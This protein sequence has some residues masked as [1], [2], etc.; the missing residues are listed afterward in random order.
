MND[1]D[2]LNDNNYDP[3]AQMEDAI[4]SN[5][6]HIR[7]TKRN[8]RKSIC[9]IEGLE[10]D[11]DKIKQIIKEMKKKFA[12]NG[13]LVEDDKLGF[14]IQLQGDIRDQAKDILIKKYNILDENIVIHG[15]D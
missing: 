14:V 7:I 8:A 2:D 4:N 1:F 13:N 15:Y 6:I 12:C 11:K 10:F 3:M 5:K 9:T